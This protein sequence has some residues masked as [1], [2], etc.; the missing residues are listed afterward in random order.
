MWLSC[1]QGRQCLRA[2]EGGEAGP[3][4]QV[5]GSL[6]RMGGGR[7]AFLYGTAALLA[8]P[9]RFPTFSRRPL[10]TLHLSS[11]LPPGGQQP[12]LLPPLKYAPASPC[13]GSGPWPGSDGSNEASPAAGGSCPD[14]AAA[15]SRHN[16][17][18]AAHGAPGLAW[19]ADLEAQ[20]TAWAGQLAAGG[21]G[22]QHGGFPSGVGQNLYAS[23][24]SGFRGGVG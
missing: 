1:A 19:S 4:V 18:R 12:L 5:Y 17:L 14:A 13:A 2:G 3:Y 22:L 10:Q 9:A 11:S 15:L 21:C 24:V 16:A 6:G 20:A 23:W 7:A 8:T